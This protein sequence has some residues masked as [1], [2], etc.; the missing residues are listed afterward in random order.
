MKAKMC[1][2]GIVLVVLPNQSLPIK[3]GSWLPELLSSGARSEAD[4]AKL[5]VQMASAGKADDFAPGPT[6]A[7]YAF[8]QRTIQRNLYRVPLP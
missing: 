2:S 8:S 7:I 3:T 5:G 4:I 6:P 1:P